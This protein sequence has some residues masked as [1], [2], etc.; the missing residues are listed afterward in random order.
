MSG[1]IP[2]ASRRS[3]RPGGRRRSRAENAVSS[4]ILNITLDCADPCA[5][6]RFW[7]QV[8]G[9]P[10]IEDPAPDFV[11]APRAADSAI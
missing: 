3:L 1:L 11:D 8:T 2:R 5:L 9:W 10:L 7:A 4:I 6:A